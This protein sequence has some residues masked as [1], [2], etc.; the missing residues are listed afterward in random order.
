MS[1]DAL[2]L[3]GSNRKSSQPYLHQ[4]VML[5]LNSDSKRATTRIHNGQRGNQWCRVIR[6]IAECLRRFS[7]RPQW[8]QVLQVLPHPLVPAQV[9]RLLLHRPVPEQVLVQ[10][11]RPVLRQVLLRHLAT[12]QVTPHRPVPQNL[13][14]PQLTALIPMAAKHTM[15]ISACIMFQQLQLVPAIP[16]SIQ[17]IQHQ[18]TK[19]TE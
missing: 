9:L 13:R 7:I 4:D 5:N 12:L 17:L 10:T 2:Q 18:M 15:C 14:Q 16:A 19:S 8:F 1:Q 11:H 6:V 3:H